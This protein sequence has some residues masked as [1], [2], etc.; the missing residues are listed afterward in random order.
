MMYSNQCLS[1]RET[2]PL[3]RKL[4]WTKA[5]SRGRVP[6]CRD[7]VPKEADLSVPGVD[8]LLR[9]VQLSSQPFDLVVLPLGRGQIG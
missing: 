2:V 7:V 6:L 1:F 8:E 9:F 3:T 5:Q 4:A